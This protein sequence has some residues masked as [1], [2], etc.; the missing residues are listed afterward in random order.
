MDNSN[1]QTHAHNKWAVS[2]ALKWFKDNDIQAHED[3]GS[4]YISVGG[5]FQNLEKF[6]IQIST[7]EVAYRA[8]L[9]ASK[10][11]NK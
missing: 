8:D 2:L 9:Q 5:G 4:I 3:N 7:A 6:D 11:I 10:V 1:T